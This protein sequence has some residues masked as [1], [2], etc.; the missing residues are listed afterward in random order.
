[1]DNLNLKQALANTF[2]SL[3]YSYSLSEKA[4]TNLEQVVAIRYYNRLVSLLPKAI[5]TDLAE[6]NHQKVIELAKEFIDQSTLHDQL[7]SIIKDVIS[8][9]LEEVTTEL[10]N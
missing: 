6:G 3:G 8:E 5:T 9:Y 7:L 1:M 2:K 10:H 4:I